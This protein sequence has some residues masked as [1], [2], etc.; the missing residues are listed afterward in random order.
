MMYKMSTSVPKA[1]AT[2]INTKATTSLPVTTLRGNLFDDDEELLSSPTADSSTPKAK[3]QSATI[4]VSKS[5]FDEDDEESV[6]EAKYYE[7]RALRMQLEARMAQLESKLALLENKLFKYE[8]DFDWK[9]VQIPTVSGRSIASSSRRS[10]RL[11]VR[12]APLVLSPDPE[13]RLHAAPASSSSSPIEIVTSA[14]RETE[15]MQDSNST[16]N[17]DEEAFTAEST[18]S[19]RVSELAM[20]RQ[21]KY[22]ATVGAKSARRRNLRATATRNAHSDPA[23][24]IS[25]K[26]QD[27]PSPEDVPIAKDALNMAPPQDFADVDPNAAAGEATSDNEQPDSK[28]V[29]QLD[30]LCVCVLIACVAHGLIVY[31]FVSC[32][33][34]LLTRWTLLIWLSA[35]CRRGLGEKISSQC[36]AHLRTSIWT[37]KNFPRIYST[38]LLIQQMMFG[39]PTCE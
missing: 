38:R 8:P 33:Q 2:S 26:A 1:E 35:W 7:E 37:L 29:V 36:F 39:R 28:C 34:M 5:L 24:A 31:S 20:R 4:S 11:S 21:R 9:D 15:Q 23:D 30:I 14:S 22:A 6:F 17:E 12:G 16:N 25:I 3:Q 13:E 32:A 19:L 27:D 18:T 10:V